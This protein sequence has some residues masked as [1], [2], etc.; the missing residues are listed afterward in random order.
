ML[1]HLHQVLFNYSKQNSHTA[2]P[3]LH[4]TWTY[5]KPVSSGKLSQSRGSKLQV[6]AGNT[7][8]L[9]RKKISVLGCSVKGRFHCTCNRHWKGSPLLIQYTLHSLGPFTEHGRDCH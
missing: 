5:E 9:Q 6:R 4:E 7:S 1:E 3:V 8:R 2:K